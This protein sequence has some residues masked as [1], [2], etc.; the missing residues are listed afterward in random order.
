[1]RRINDFFRYLP[2]WLRRYLFAFGQLTFGTALATLSLNAFGTKATLFVSLIGDVVFLGCAW[3]GYGEGVVAGILITFVIPHLLLPRTPLHPD[4]GRFGLVL[5]VSLLVSSISSYRRKA[6]R[7]LKFAADELESRVQSRTLELQKNE[8]RLRENARLLDLAPVGV[9][10]TDSDDV[11][12]YWSQGAAQMYGWTSQEAVGQS[13]RQLLRFSVSIEEVM[14]ALAA[15]GV[16]ETELKHSRKDGSE[17]TVASRWASQ[18]QANGQISGFLQVNSD[19][20]ERKRALDQIRASETRFRQLADSMPQIVWTASENGSIEYLNRQ[21]YEFTESGSAGDLTKEIQ[22]L[23]HPDDRQKH[24]EGWRS[25]V[26]ANESYESEIRL[27]DPR[28]GG[29]RWFLCRGLFADDYPSSIRW[30]GTFTDINQQKITERNLHRANDELR[31]FA[32]AAAHDMQE[33]LRN[34]VLRL[35]MFRREHENQFDPA[36]IERIHESIVDAQR[37]HTMV[38]DLLLF[39]N[40]LDS[41]ENVETFTDATDSLREALANLAAAIRENSAELR[42][43]FLPPLRVQRFHLTQLFQNLIGNALKYRKQDVAPIIDIS[44]APAGDEWVFSV[45]DNGIGFDPAYAERIFGVFKRLHHHHKYPGTG[46]GLAICARIVLHYGGRIWAEGEP[47]KGATFRFALPRQSSS[48]IM[49][50]ANQ[51]CTGSSKATLAR[52]SG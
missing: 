18:T 42:F 16:W 23:V 45:V 36:T 14:T 20:T 30:F 12:R 25:A 33:P 22:S 2:A 3:L 46:I 38:K 5:V 43:D 19:I 13:S 51:N 41:P 7:A 50:T 35:S 44:A 37:M 27:A 4:V 21:W 49:W 17:I 10:S 52:D 26:A 11:I 31:Q 15:T 48:N 34:I 8:Q 29:H 47:G 40:A 1:M 9:L 6:E 24:I 28:T 39:S 32:Y